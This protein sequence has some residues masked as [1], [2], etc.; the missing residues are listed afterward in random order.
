[1]TTQSASL[2]ER[3]NYALGVLTEERRRLLE[4]APNATLDSER[5]S[6]EKARVLDW[7][8]RRAPTPEI[9]A[10]MLAQYAPDL[11]ALDEQ[12][13]EPETIKQRIEQL[14]PLIDQARRARDKHAQATTNPWGQ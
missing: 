14:K 10:E 3:F 12:I 8:G 5:A 13:A 1:M 6:V 2:H 7:I 11:A 9:N 4:R